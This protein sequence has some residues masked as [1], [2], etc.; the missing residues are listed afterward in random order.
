MNNNMKKLI[1]A[2][3]KIDDPRRQWGN[4]RHKLVDVLVIAFCAILCG[5]QTYDDLELFGKARKTW[6]SLYLE[7]QSAIPSADTFERIF[8]L[9]RSEKCCKKIAENSYL[10]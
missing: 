8:E 5:A 3:E 10:R 7:L 2:A 1:R 9:V 6:L 4:L